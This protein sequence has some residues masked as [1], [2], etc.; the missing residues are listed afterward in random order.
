MGKWVGIQRRKNK[1]GQ[2]N[3]DRVRR[4]NGIEFTWWD[5]FDVAWEEMFVALVAY[6]KKYGD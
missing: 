6:K 2:L 1:A 3:S 5:M 4:L